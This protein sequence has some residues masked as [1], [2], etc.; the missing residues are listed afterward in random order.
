MSVKIWAVL[1]QCPI[2]MR[3]AFL[4]AVLTWCAVILFEL[5]FAN[6]RGL[7]ATGIIAAVSLTILWVGHLLAFA[8]KVTSAV[9]PGKTADTLAP[10]RRDMISIF[11]RAF[12][13]AAAV[14]AGPVSAI[15][16]M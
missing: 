13:A 7:L 12:A 14:S 1:G 11:A 16:Q 9:A 6:N 10:S 5:A 15:A 8:Q 4:A 2:C 3:K